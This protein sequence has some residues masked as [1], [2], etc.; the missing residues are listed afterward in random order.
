MLVS[1]PGEWLPTNNLPNLKL[2]VENF[3]SVL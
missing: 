1:P 3:L 2:P